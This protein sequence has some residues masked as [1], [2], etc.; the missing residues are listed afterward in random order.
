MP[1]DA[2]DIQVAGCQVHLTYHAL[3]DGGWTV[4]GV[5]RCGGAEKVEEQSVA[6]GPFATREAAEK[7]ALDRLG[8]VLGN[9][10][11]R[12]TSRV[13]NWR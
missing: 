1:E 12:S 10:I 11:D 2:K 6:T 13:K 8:K 3:A 5:V 4:M 7:D 9:N